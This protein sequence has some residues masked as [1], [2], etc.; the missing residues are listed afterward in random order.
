LSGLGSWSE[1]ARVESLAA[2]AACFGA[3]VLIAVNLLKATVFSADAFVHQF[4]MWSWRDGQ[5]FTDS[6]TAQ[7]RGSARYPDGYEALFW[8]ATHVASP[9][10]FGEWLGIAL[11]AVSGWLVWAIVREHTS[12][13]PAA[14]IAAV[15]FLALMDIH[16]FYGG[17]PRAF[18][19]PAVLLAVLLAMR[20]RHLPAALVSV[21]SALFY[22]TAA[23]LAA[24]V[25]VVSAVGWTDRRPRLE[26]P[27]LW[28]ALAALI[29]TVVAV[30]VPALLSGGTPEVFTADEARRYPEFGADGALGFFVPS[31]IDYLAQNRSGFDLGGSG[32]ILAVAAL[33][34]LAFRPANLRLLRREVLAMPVVALAGFAA[35]HAVLFQLYLPHRYTYPL[36][37]FF[38]I[39]VAV[40]LRP[41]W[42][43]LWSRPRPRLPAFLMLVAPLAVYGFAVYVFPL[44]PTRELTGAG[45]AV[46][47]AAGALALAAAVALALRGRAAPALGALVT[48]AAVTGAM[49]AST[50]EWAR[51]TVCRAEGASGFIAGLPKDA[52]IAGDP[53]DLRCIPATARRPVVTSTQLA[54]AYE[55]DYFLDNRERMF[56]TLR[57]YYGPSAG[58]IA[59]LGERYGATHLWVR[60]KAVRRV[61]AS[62]GGHWREGD[63]P[64][65]RFIADLLRQGEPAVLDLPAECRRWR[66]AESEI[67]DIACIAGTS[68]RGMLTRADGVSGRTSCAARLTPARAGRGR[69]HR[70][71]NCGNCRGA[72]PSRLLPGRTVF[73]LDACSASRSW[74]SAEAR[75]GRRRRPV[76]PDQ[77]TIP[78]RFAAD[79]VESAVSEDD[80]VTRRTWLAAERTWLAWWRTALGACVAALGVGRVVPDLADVERWPFVMLGAGYALLAGIV[81]AAG[82]WRWRSTEDALRRGDFSALDRRL[83][84]A[85]T[86]AGLALVA[87]TIALLFVEL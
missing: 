45:T 74:R 6:L 17:F 27:R 13:R 69:P 3:S 72:G 5:L 53:R 12:W 60:P 49:L 36:H 11:M 44:G 57:A 68:A 4:W 24:G 47:V 46:A 23:L 65:G 56:A 43:A 30:L 84:G 51:G 66:N 63:A 64:Y 50:E 77:L 9:L 22:P 18:V 80:D 39:A 86:A 35:A 1:R 73:G 59:A 2:F 34:L 29:G 75:R 32:A 83:T 70:T 33:A 61:M 41:T 7:L 14:W 54:P 16:R 15:L 79:A 58:A 85:L 76:D 8:L 55:V 40:S 71:A 67:Y 48:A 82:A 78:L 52:V 87:A 37:A 31:T 81:F 62:G 21:A 19:H 42:T 10:T 38:A 26:R 25:L 28:F 20:R